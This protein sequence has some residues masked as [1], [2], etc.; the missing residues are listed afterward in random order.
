MNADT[1]LS[2]KM[3]WRKYTSLSDFA[4]AIIATVA[5]LF[6]NLLPQLEKVPYGVQKSIVWAV[7]L[8]IVLILLIALNLGIK[9]ESVR[10]FKKGKR[11]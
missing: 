1:F 3:N 9:T 10:K 7:A 2:V 6:S 5:A 11:S 8:I 4:A